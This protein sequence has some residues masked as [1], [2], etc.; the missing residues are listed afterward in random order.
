MSLSCL[1]DRRSWSTKRP[2]IPKGYRK[3]LFLSYILDWVLIIIFI[4]VFFLL[5]YTHPIR[6]EFS[7]TDKDISR[8][9]HPKDTVSVPVVFVLAFL[10]P[11]AIILFIG[12]ILRRSPHD[13]H[14]GFLGLALSLS[15]TI[16]ITMV[17]KVTVGEHRPD[18]LD[19][20]KPQAGVVNPEFGLVGIDVCTG[21]QDPS[22]MKD[23]MRSFP[24]GHSSFAFSGMSFLSLFLAGK[25]HVFDGRG[26][27]IK[28]FICISPLVAGLLVGATRLWDNRHHPVDIFMGGLLGILFSFFSY[29]QYYPSL[30]SRQCHRPFPPRVRRRKVDGESYVHAD[31]DLD[32]GEGPEGGLSPARVNEALPPTTEESMTT[33]TTCRSS[34]NVHQY[35]PHQ[36]REPSLIEKAEE[37][38]SPADSGESALRHV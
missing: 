30:S 29:F 19:R 10:A 7:L 20:C 18:W 17:L 5:E 34:S 13:F 21:G 15:L 27:A 36:P 3:A 22:V 9:Y 11:F 8:T 26:L 6:R 25:L 28:S 16:C 38:Y 14:Q 37:P 24:S 4:V 2:P 23:G 33:D 32:H 35:S 1:T 31:L 12:L